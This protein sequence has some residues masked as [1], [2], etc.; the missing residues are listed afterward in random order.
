MISITA[1]LSGI[2]QNPEKVPIGHIEVYNTSYTVPSNGIFV[3]YFSG[4][5]PYL[6][7]NNRRTQFE[8]MIMKDWSNGIP[9]ELSNYVGARISNSGVWVADPFS[10]VYS[11]YFYAETP[12]SYSFATRSNGG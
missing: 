6:T 8:S 1:E 12:G 11:G 2:I 10:V 3:R 9:A 7:G 5:Q 4:V